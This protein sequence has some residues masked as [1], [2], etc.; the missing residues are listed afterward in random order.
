MGP[1]AGPTDSWATYNG[2]LYMNFMPSIRHNFFSK[3]TDSNIATADQ[4]WIEWWGGL[5]AG[6]F[7]TDCLAETWNDYPCTKYAQPVPPTCLNR[8][9]DSQF[10][11][12]CS[13]KRCAELVDTQPCDQ[14]YCFNCSFSGWCDKQC[15]I[16]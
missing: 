1:P 13:H 5:K 11:A 16:C 7:N 9:Y 4:R 10:A 2:S 6:P 15:G 12:Q 3:E 8:C 14:Y